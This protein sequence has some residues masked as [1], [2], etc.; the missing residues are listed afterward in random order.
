MDLMKLNYYGTLVI[1]VAMLSTAAAITSQALDIT[2]IESRTGGTNLAWYHELTGN[3]QNSSVK[4]TAP[5]TTQAS[6]SIG[7]RF[8][9]D[10]GS[11]FFVSPVLQDG[12]TYAV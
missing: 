12:A 11:T 10:V 8:S 5:G 6:P 7:S 3:W 1:R 2:I 9:T 4:S